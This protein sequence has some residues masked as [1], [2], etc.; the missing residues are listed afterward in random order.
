MYQGKYNGHQKHPADLEHVVQ[1]A[2]KS[3]LDKI[4]VTVGTL[5]E[6][7]AALDIVA[8]DGKNY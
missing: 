8:K 4:I 2:W 3:G 1:R 5:N 7:P 6:Y